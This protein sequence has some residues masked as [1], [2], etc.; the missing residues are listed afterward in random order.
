MPGSPVEIKIDELMQQLGE[1]GSDDP[2]KAR[3]VEEAARRARKYGGSLI[4]ASQSADDYYANK[5]MEAAFQ[6]ADWMFLLRQNPESIARLA[7]EGK[8][9]SD[10]SKR[11]VLNSLHTEPGVFSEF[12]VKN[13][14]LGEG[15]ARLIIDPWTLLLAEIGRAHV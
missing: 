15:L 5:Q 10:D 9:V 13:A 4:T 6:Q 14:N 8:L 7:T 3:V 11:R 1:I 2:V 12:Y